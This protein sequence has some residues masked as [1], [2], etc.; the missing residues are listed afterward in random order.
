MRLLHHPVAVAGE[1][2]AGDAPHQRLLLRQTRD[3]EGDELGQV[4]DHA[5]HAALRDG[6]QRQ[7]AGLLDLPLGVE[8]RL[9]QDGQQHRQQLRQE[10]V[11]QHVQSSRGALPEVPVRQR[12]VIIQPVILVI[13]HVVYVGVVMAPGPVKP[14][15]DILFPVRNILIVLVDISAEEDDVYLGVLHATH[16]HGHQLVQ[17]GLQHLLADGLLGQAQPELAGLERHALVLVL[18]PLQHVVDDVVHLRHQSVQSHLQQHHDGPTDVLTNLRV[19]VTGQ[20]EE[21]LYELVYMNHQRLTAPDD[22]LVNTGDG[23]RSDLRIVVS[24][25]CQKLKHKH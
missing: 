14:R 15:L 20:E 17:V 5:R 10:H 13:I 22:E 2:P 12:T 6:S 23:V 18:G 19:L 3:Q 1:G 16:Q 9:L 21:V 7:D 4:R 25:K 11:G 8:Q 24:E